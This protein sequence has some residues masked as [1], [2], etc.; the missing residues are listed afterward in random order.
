MDNAYAK[1]DMFLTPKP[2]L[3]IVNVLQIPIEII[4]E[5]VFAISDIF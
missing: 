2:L 1:L 3:V 5:Y 4:K